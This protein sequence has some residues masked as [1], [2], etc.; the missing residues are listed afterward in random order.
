[1][2]SPAALGIEHSGI[3]GPE[4]GAGGAPQAHARPAPALPCLQGNNSIGRE[5]GKHRRNKNRQYR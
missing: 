1:M 4:A 2:T 5:E 3:G